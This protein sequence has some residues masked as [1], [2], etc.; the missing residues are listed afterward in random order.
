MTRDGTQAPNS[1]CGIRILSWATGATVSN[2]VVG[3]SGSR[4]D[5]GMYVLAPQTTITNCSV[6]VTR[7]GTR[8]PNTHH[9]I[10][11]TPGH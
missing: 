7:D 8:V 9:G 3:M 10:Y 11:I 1:I 4:S 5:S 2:T 6:G